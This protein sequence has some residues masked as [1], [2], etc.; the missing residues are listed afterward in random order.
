MQIGTVDPTTTHA[1][2]D[3]E[4]AVALGF[5]ALAM[6]LGAPTADWAI[7]TV[8]QLFQYAQGTNLGLFFSMD[9]GQDSSLDD[10]TSIVNQYL[11][12]GAYYKGP[13]GQ[14]FLS[15]YSSG[16]HSPSDFTSFLSGLS[17]DVYFVPDLDDSSGYYTDAP[18]WFT[19]WDDV[20]DGVYSWETAWPLGSSTPA[21]TST[22]QDVYV[23]TSATSADKTYM[24]GKVAYPKVTC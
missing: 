8:E 12:N 18:D 9:L 14:P 16:G 24:I 23:Q 22:T 11:G 4:N 7:S 20:V 1:Q 2:Q 21:N 15:T 13:T 5:D 19:T 10:F 3:V 17:S 6:N